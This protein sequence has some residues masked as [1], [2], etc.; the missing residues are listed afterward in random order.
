MRK[1]RLIFAISDEARA[2]PGGVSPVA[3]SAVL[4]VR[5]RISK[6]WADLAKSAEKSGAV[7][8]L[9]RGRPRTFLQ[10]LYHST[11]EDDPAI[12]ALLEVVKEIWPDGRSLP[13]HT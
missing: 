11:R 10:L 13:A 2:N 6:H 12:L 4:M 8:V 1:S 5:R 7:L 3:R 9:D